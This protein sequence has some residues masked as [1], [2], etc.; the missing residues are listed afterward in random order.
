MCKLSNLINLL[1]M[2]QIICLMYQLKLTLMLILKDTNETIHLTVD[3]AR[4]KKHRAYLAAIISAIVYCIVDSTLG[5]IRIVQILD[6]NYENE[7]DTQYLLLTIFDLVCM[8]TLFIVY[9]IT[10]IQL[11][12]KVKLLPGMDEEKKSIVI[13]V[14]VFGLAMI[15]IISFKAWDLFQ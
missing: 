13:Q 8:V 4:Q 3:H 11:L 14:S 5:V 6:Q 1:F 15:I 2:V 7:N 10:I 12:Q 9:G